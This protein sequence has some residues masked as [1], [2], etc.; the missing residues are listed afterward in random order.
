LGFALFTVESQ[1]SR[2]F[3]SLGQ[4]PGELAES[5]IDIGGEIVMCE[6]LGRVPGIG[7]EQAFNNALA[8]INAEI[9]PNLAV[10]IQV[11]SAQ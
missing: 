1:C 10:Y 8:G 6:L 4:V 9:H 5:R 11:V 3:D 7:R 2:D